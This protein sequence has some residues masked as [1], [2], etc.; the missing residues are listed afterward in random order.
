MACPLKAIT[1]VLSP[2]AR[3][4]RDKPSK[5]RCRETLVILALRRL[6]L[7]ATESQ[8][9]LGC[10]ARPCLE[11]VGAP[12]SNSEKQGEILFCGLWLP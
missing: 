11:R 10:T 8:V 2:F 7:E 4:H 6:H 1:H 12:D 3:K 9:S 5:S